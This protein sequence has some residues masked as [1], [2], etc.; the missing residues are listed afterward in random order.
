MVGLRPVMGGGNRKIHA[1]TGRQLGLVAD[2]ALPPTHKIMEL[3]LIHQHEINAGRAVSSV[4]AVIRK[5]AK[6]SAQGRIHNVRRNNERELAVGI[7]NELF[8]DQMI[9]RRVWSCIRMV[10]HQ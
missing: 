3:L 8:M 6:V 9:C 2:I 1:L 7:H 4:R 10:S 5:R